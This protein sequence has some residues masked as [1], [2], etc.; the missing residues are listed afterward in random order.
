MHCSSISLTNFRNYRQLEVE[1]PNGPILVLGSN[2]TGKTTLL[3]ALYLLS[4]TKSH[5]TSSERELVSWDARPELGLPPFARVYAQ[6]QKR[7][8]LRVELI[9]VREGAE[10]ESGVARKRIRVND[11][12]KRAIDLLGQVNAVMFGPQDL[13]LIVGPPNLRRRY[14]DIM[15]SQ[16]DPHYVRAL[17]TYLKVVAQR[18]SLLKTVGDRG[19]RG[20]GD[21]IG[22]QLRYW[23]DELVLHG[24]QLLHRR[25][26]VIG[27]LN[28]LADTSHARVAGTSE[29]LELLYRSTVTD[30]TRPALEPPEHGALEEAYRERLRSGRAD[31]LRRAMTLA[32]PHRDDLQFTVGGV[33]MG[34][35]GSR[36][37]QRSVILALKLAE[38]ELMRQA[39]GEAPL[40]LLDDVVSELDPERRRYLLQAVLERPQQVLV[41]AT[42]LVPVGREFLS[43]ASLFETTAS[44][45]LQARR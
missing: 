42:D 2:A 9:I 12:P 33:N 24:T 15:I 36:G 43:R 39:T 30:E 34:T 19:F 18:N 22:D 7:G 28:R 45:A 29:T 38:V 5:R 44:G 17:G 16:I 10:G 11:L 37:Q 31:E 13:E 25:L 41:T 8:P 4:T 23:D 27:E 1:L 20:G 14:L 26:E 40:L 3:E 21:G 35:Y 6:V 32:G